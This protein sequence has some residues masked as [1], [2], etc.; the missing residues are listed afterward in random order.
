M[1]NY[2]TLEY[3]M[4]IRDKESMIL[5]CLL[6]CVDGYKDDPELMYKFCTIYNDHYKDYVHA[7]KKVGELSECNGD[8]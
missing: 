2:G 5:E 6:D 8:A 1:Y 7:C 4:D 3:W